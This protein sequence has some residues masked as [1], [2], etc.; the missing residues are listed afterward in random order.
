MPLFGF[1]A[2]TTKFS[3]SSEMSTKYCLTFARWR[4]NSC[5]G[6]NTLNLGHFFRDTGFRRESTQ[7]RRPKQS[8]F[9]SSPK[10]S[11]TFDKIDPLKVAPVMSSGRCICLYHH[12][13]Q[14][15]RKG[16]T[17]IPESSLMLLCSQFLLS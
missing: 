9:S 3:L 17:I 2:F 12:H 1:Q 11:L 7:K 8:P 5:K 6:G 13:I 16:I 4:K 14:D 15:I 10:I